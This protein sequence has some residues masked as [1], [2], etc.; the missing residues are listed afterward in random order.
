MRI[1]KQLAQL[2]N[3]TLD[4]TDCDFSVFYETIANCGAFKHLGI[5]SF[6]ELVEMRNKL[7]E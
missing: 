4:M 2:L 3:E 7:K 5:E 6:E 1:R